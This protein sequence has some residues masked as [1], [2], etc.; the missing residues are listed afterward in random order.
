LTST[1]IASLALVMLVLMCSSR[2]SCEFAGFLLDLRIMERSLKDSALGFCL[3][4]ER[5]QFL[6]PLTSSFF[7]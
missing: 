3:S 7:Q 5:K 1:A 2:S 4:A 6:A